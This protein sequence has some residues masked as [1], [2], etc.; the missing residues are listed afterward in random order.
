MAARGRG[1][2]VTRVIVNPAAAN[3]GALRRLNGLRARL[4][5]AFG[6]LDW[7]VTQ[8]AEEITALARGAAD[9]GHPQVLVA[10][11][12]G[13]VH[14]A[15]NGVAG[16]PTAL[17]IVPVGTGNDVAVS[18]G[19]PTDPERALE[20]LAER[21]VRAIDV[22]AVGDR[23]YVCVL[24]VGLD[25]PALHLLERLRAFGRSRVLYSYAALH[26]LV[27]YRPRAIAVTHA[28]GR[29]ELPV[30][31]AAVTN[32]QTYAG[33]MRICPAAR[34]DDGLLDL[35]VIAGQPWPRLLRLFRR[36]VAGRHA[37]RPGVLLAQTPWVRFES[38]EP[39]PITLD[40]EL[41]PLSIPLEVRAR[42]GALRVLGGKTHG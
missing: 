34:V 10:G 13:S 6:P 12:D 14:F 36:V 19:L 18:V 22:G 37:G 4:E 42:P 33:G 17:A 8:R 38:R 26:T 25:T 29:V 1:A 35:C 30:A 32:T 16:S 27:T 9:A 23:V 15:A 31:F 20:V 3:G 39:V 40:G 41:T 21:H 24:G 5:T 2:D 11:G 28:H 7:R